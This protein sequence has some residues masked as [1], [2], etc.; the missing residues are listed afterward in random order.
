MHGRM[1]TGKLWVCKSPV[2]YRKE[3]ESREVEELFKRS[4]VYKIAKILHLL[5]KKFAS[6]LPFH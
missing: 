6:L 3:L 5:S 2:Q 1:A 4:F